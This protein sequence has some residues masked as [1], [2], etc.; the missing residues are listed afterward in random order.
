MK[1]YVWHKQT[2][3]PDLEIIDCSAYDPLKDFRRDPTGAYVLIRCEG[4][5]GVIEVA[6]CDK[7]HVITHVFRGRKA[8]DLYFSLFEYEK[9]HGTAWFDR[10]DHAAYLGKELKK[11]ELALEG[12]GDYVQE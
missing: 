3:S 9:E 1:D 10:K 2:V 5:Q 8:Q 11:A 12:K 7:N 6:V 4:A